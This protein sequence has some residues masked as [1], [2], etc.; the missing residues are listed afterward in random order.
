MKLYLIG[1]GGT[2]ARVIKSLIMLLATGMDIKAKTIVPIIID[3]H[4]SNEDRMRTDRLL[5]TYKELRNHLNQPASGFLKTEVVGLS[6][7][8][9]M[10]PNM[11]P[12]FYY[13]FF[14]GD[15]KDQDFR[16]FIDFEGLNSV[17]PELRDL[18]LGLF[19]MES[20]SNP[21]TVGF[22][23]NPNLGSVVLNQLAN[24]PLLKSIGKSFSKGDRIFII[25]SIFGGTGAA[26]FPVLLR[27][28]R[29]PNAGFDEKQLMYTSPIGALTVMPYFG[30]TDNESSDID[31]NSFVTKTITALRYYKKYLTDDLNALYYIGDGVDPVI[32]PTDEE[33][34]RNQAHFVELVGALSVVNFCSNNYSEKTESAFYQYAFNAYRE[35]VLALTF[36]HLPENTKGL[37]GPALVKFSLFRKFISEYLPTAR[38]SKKAWFSIFQDSAPAELLDKS[39]PLNVA[40][41]KLLS[42]YGEWMSELRH[43]QKENRTKYFGP[44]NHNGHWQDVVVDKPYELTDDDW[45]VFL[46]KQTLAHKN[47]DGNSM[48][49]FIQELQ[50]VIDQLYAEKIQNLNVAQT[51]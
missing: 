18:M 24:F 46:N 43:E 23:G 37:I 7:L 10:D 29:R 12:G 9:G 21:L 42:I 5:E 1:I 35:E 17:S 32:I 41:D 49:K 44:V 45:D 20:M 36:K 13:D 22:K 47:S 11:D 50:Q 51:K 30:L 3:P 33:N 31:S 34:Q 38:A 8:D 25:S 28:L 26:G 19:D 4:K 15:N 14:D 6:D 48:L 2:G 39:L 27:N 40:L 16:N